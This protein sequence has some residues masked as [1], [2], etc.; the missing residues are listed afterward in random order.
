MTNLKKSKVRIQDTQ[1]TNILS[2][3]MNPEA[4]LTPGIAG[5]LVM[6][7][8]NSLAVNFNLSRAYTGLLL[9]F[10]FGL[11]VI[12]TA[13]RWWIR[14]VYYV[15]NSLIIFC[16]AFGANGVGVGI[17]GAE[18]LSFQPVGVALAQAGNAA[19]KKAAG[20]SGRE[21][22]PPDRSAPPKRDEKAPARQDTFFK[23]W[24]FR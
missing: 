16:V 10:V 15:L 18:K 7:I 14:I 22:H 2:Q 1:D 9:S 8:S 11:L 23:P 4:M 21:N 24:T 19:G 17:S 13:R 12:A 5:A 6:A 3:F 20:S